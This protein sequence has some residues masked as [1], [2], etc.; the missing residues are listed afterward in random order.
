MYEANNGMA[1]LEEAKRRP[2]EVV[3]LLK[4]DDT[5]SSCLSLRPSGHLMLPVTESRSCFHANSEDAS[6]TKHI[7]IHST[8]LTPWAARQ[9]PL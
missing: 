8:F 7:L 4:A 3:V 9:E 6:S 2:S 1:L 5:R